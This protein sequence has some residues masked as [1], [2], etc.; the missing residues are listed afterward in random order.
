MSNQRSLQEGIVLQHQA[1]ENQLSFPKNA[2]PQQEE[3]FEHMVPPTTL[4]IPCCSLPVHFALT[5][6]YSEH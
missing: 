1:G 5:E 2:I 3:R 6:A 4:Q